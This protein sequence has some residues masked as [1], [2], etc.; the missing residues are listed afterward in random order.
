MIEGVSSSSMISEAQSLLKQQKKVEA[1]ELFIEAC[2][3][4][5]DERP[6][7]VEPLSEQEYECL[8]TLF[9]LYVSALSEGVQE[10]GSIY[11]L[12]E[13]VEREKKKGLV[14]ATLIQTM[15]FANEGM[16]EH[17][18]TAFYDSYATN[19][20]CR[21]HPLAHKIIA[22]V[23]MRAYDGTIDPGLKEKYRRRAVHELLESFSRYPHDSTIIEKLVFLTVQ[24]KNTAHNGDSEEKILERKQVA[25]SLFS[26]LVSSDKA[27][28]RR[29]DLFLLIDYL[30]DNG[31]KESAKKL[32]QKAKSWYQYSRRLNQY[33]ESL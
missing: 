33:E 4:V 7:K 23:A 30:I 18:F 9:P 2:D 5:E 6:V 29:E 12:Q 11:E 27:P 1:F 19:A 22:V 28:L 16:I 13:A 26:S 25:L 15:L 24:S 14:S 21:S 32:I 17:L 8:N 10:E 20:Q 3:K 31:E